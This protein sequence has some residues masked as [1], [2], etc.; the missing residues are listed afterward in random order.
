MENKMLCSKPIQFL[1]SVMVLSVTA[2]DVQA[3]EV[4]KIGIAGPLTGAE[5]HLGKD[6]ENGARLAVQDLNRQGISI[7]NNHVTFELISEDDQG[8]P[9]TA[10][11]VAQR[12][13]DDGVKGVVGHL[14]SGPTIAASRIYAN[15]GIPQI[16]TAATNPTYTLQGF[17]T[18]FRLMATDN[19]QGS[20]LASLAQKLAGSGSVAIVDDRSAYGQ[21]LA[22]EVA[23]NLNEHHVPIVAREYTNENAVEFSSILTKLKGERPAVIVYGGADAQAGP[24]VRRMKTL[25]ITAAFIGGDGVCTSNWATLASGAAEG[26]YCTQAGSPH[27]AMPKYADFEARFQKAYGKIVAFAP[28]AYDATMLL[29]KAM[30]DAN[31][32][33]PHVYGHFLA[34]EKY[35]GITGLVSFTPTGDNANGT[36]VVYQITKGEL[37]P[38]TQ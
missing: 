12:L 22:D 29:A 14:S 21:G 26:Q 34:K 19:Q 20:T 9:K 18:T 3:D 16:A 5:A 28:Y 15:A 30:Q 2:V 13:V 6:T 1:L 36:V 31:S 11:Q 32:T 25:G 24:M 10:V 4:V 23:K 37:V 17:P 27:S 7:A 38:V 8:D 33:D 35:N